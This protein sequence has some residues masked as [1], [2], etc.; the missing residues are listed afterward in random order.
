[1]AGLLHRLAIQRKQ[2]ARILLIYHGAPSELALDLLMILILAQFGN[3]T[4]GTTGARYR[5][6]YV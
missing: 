6:F 4:G 1:M 3:T 5:L 2:V